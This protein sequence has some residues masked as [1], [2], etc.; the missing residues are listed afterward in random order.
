[1]TE[2]DPINSFHVHGNFFDYFPTGHVA[3]AG[4]VH[5]HGHAVPG[6]ARDP[7]A[8][9]P[10]HRPVHVPRAPVRVHGAGMAGVLRGRRLMPA[11]GPP[12]WL[13]GLVPLAARRA[14]DRGS[15]RC[16]TGPGLGERTGPPV[17]ELAVERT[18]LEPGDDRADR[19]ATTGPTR[20]TIAQAQVNDAFVAVHRRRGADRPAGSPRRVR[21]AAPVG[22]G[23]GVRRRAADRRP[24]GRSRTRSPSP[25]RRP[26]TTC[27]SSG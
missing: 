13:L 12:R 11:G 16:S 7:R 24:A 3:R 1:M 23:R 15:S 6:P 18:V 25:S 5:R 8:A 2:Y 22:R 14:G 21:A 19:S 4:R 17:E 9:L 27:R 26:T 20:C 10:A